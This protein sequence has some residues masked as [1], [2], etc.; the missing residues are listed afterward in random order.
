M[1]HPP[2]IKIKIMRQFPKQPLLCRADS[3]CLDL[4]EQSP[5]G[6]KTVGVGS[7]WCA[8]RAGNRRRQKFPWR[9]CVW[10]CVCKSEGAGEGSE[11]TELLRSSTL[12]A[13]EQGSGLAGVGFPLGKSQKYT[14]L[15]LDFFPHG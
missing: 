3:V 13:L 11:D 10:M 7:R 8:G 12:G 2:N 6:V 5:G 4:E 9:Q 1:L 14:T 15:S